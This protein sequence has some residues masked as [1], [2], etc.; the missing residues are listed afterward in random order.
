MSAPSPAI[1]ART[2][3]ADD[4]NPNGPRPR[5]SATRGFALSGPEQAPRRRTGPG[6]LR[7]VAPRATSPFPPRRRPPPPAAGPGQR[8]NLAVTFVSGSAELTPAARAQ[9]QVFATAL[10]RP[11]LMNM[12]FEINGHTD[13]VGR[14]DRNLELSQRRAQ[15]VADFLVRAGVSA[16]RLVVHGYG[17]DRPLPHMRATAPQNRRVEVIRVRS[18]TSRQIPSAAVPRASLGT[19][20]D[21]DWLAR[22]NPELT[23]RLAQPGLGGRVPWKAARPDA[24]GLRAAISSC[25]TMRERIS[26]IQ[27]SASRGFCRAAR[28]GRRP[29]RGPSGPAGSAA[30]RSRRA[31]ARGSGR[32]WRRSRSLG[33]CAA[34][35]GRRQAAGDVD[36]ILAGRSRL[37]A[38]RTCAGQGAS[39]GAS[40]SRA[41]RSSTA[42]R[43]SPRMSLIVAR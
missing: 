17:P 7:S 13:A 14:R 11:Q 22:R 35:G 41:M 16:D 30:C 8:I 23:R 15:T 31:S 10:M 9:A 18:L 40:R 37:T 19:N 33:P 24:Q 27:P 25:S 5:I 12:R 4:Q 28:R 1:A 29:W 3:P 6:R 26:L 38:S 21:G 39:A 20:G 36:M 2:R 34:A 32:E 43:W 42:P